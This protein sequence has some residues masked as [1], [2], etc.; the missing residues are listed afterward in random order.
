[1]PFALPQADMTKGSLLKRSVVLPTVQA[2]KSSLRGDNRND[3]CLLFEFGNFL[4]EA[5]DVVDLA[6][7]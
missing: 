1:M 6:R 4:D 7:S 3:I 5:R 2:D